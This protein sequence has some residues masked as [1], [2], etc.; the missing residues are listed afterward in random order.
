MKSLGQA[1]GRATAE[2]GKRIA[3]ALLAPALVLAALGAAPAAA[4]GEPID[5]KDRDGPIDVD[6]DDR[7][8]PAAPGQEIVYEVEI[9]N[10]TGAV[11]PDVV[12]TSVLPP[13]TTFVVA[14]REPDWAEIQGTVVGDRVSFDLGDVVPCDR[15]GV[16]RCRDVWLVLRAD[17]SVVPGTRVEHRVEI[18]TGNPAAFPP[19]A[20]SVFTAVSSAAI[21]HATLHT[22][23]PGRDRAILDADL[24][25]TAWRTRLD[26]PPP[27]V[28]PSQGIR[29]RLDEPGGQLLTDITIPMAELRC[30]NPSAD[31]HRTR[32]CRP[33][34][35]QALKAA[36]I[37]KLELTLRATSTVQRNNA[38]IRLRL[39]RI[40]IPLGSVENLRLTLD[41]AGE[42]YT[43]TVPLAPLADGRRF[44]Y[45]RSQGEP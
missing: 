15:P 33:T 12:L 30:T 26:P 16:P 18:E 43:D 14:H 9:E 22:G 36:G 25:R 10:F 6:L 24:A 42:T 28:D 23:R 20:A 8:D 40:S 21:R 2:L 5:A 19:I 11:A 27:N 4:Q 31:P 39:A 17:E 38:R 35:R 13:G 29:V 7:V 3:F 34:N 32:T 37:Q 44:A 45:A 1:S 41:A